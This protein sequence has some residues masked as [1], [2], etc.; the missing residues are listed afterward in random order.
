MRYKANDKYS[1]NKNDHDRNGN[2]EKNLHKADIRAAMEL[3]Y[4]SSVVKA[5]RAEPDKYK[6]QRILCNARNGVYI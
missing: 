4:P 5:L 3:G 6:R 1:F 2:S